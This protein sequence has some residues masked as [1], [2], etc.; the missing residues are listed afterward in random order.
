MAFKGTHDVQKHGTK[1]WRQR[2]KVSPLQKVLSGTILVINTKSLEAGV[3]TFQRR[4]IIHSKIDG[5]V[6]IKNGVISV[7]PLVAKAQ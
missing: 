3:N 1:A 5:V 7:K 6:Q 2:L 4:H